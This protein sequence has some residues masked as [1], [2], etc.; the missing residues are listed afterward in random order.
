MEKGAIGP[1]KGAQ[2]PWDDIHGSKKHIK[3][4]VEID[5]KQLNNV[6]FVLSCMV[7]V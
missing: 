4:E 2:I 6:Q 5:V 7:A 1:L 3:R